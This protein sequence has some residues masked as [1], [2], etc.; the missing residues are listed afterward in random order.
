MVPA[1]PDAPHVNP[2]PEARNRTETPKP[3]GEATSSLTLTIWGPDFMAPLDEV[4]GGPALAGQ[5]RAFEEAS[6]NCRVHYVRKKPYGQG[7]LVH[8]I[9]STQ[10]VAPE[11]LPDLALVDM[12]EI[13]LLAEASL[14]QPLDS[15]VDPQIV[16]DL[17][18]FARDAGQ[19]GDH[20]LALQYETD[21]RFLAYNSAIIAQPPGTWAQVLALQPNYLLPIGATDGAVL[22]SFLPQYLALG[23]KLVDRDGRPYL[24]R[25]LVEAILEVYRSGRATGVLPAA[26]FDLDDASDCWP[27]YLTSRAAMT[28]VNSW[29]YGRERANRLAATQ[30]APMPTLSGAQISMSNGWGWVVL[31]DDPKRQAAAADFLRAIFEPEA[32]AAWSRVT[33]HLPTRRAALSLAVDDAGYRNFL[34]ELA[35]V[36]VPQPREPVLSLATEALREAIESVTRGRQTP[37]AAAAEAADRV[38]TAL[39]QPETSSQ[40]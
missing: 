2:A 9:Q 14:L 37:R 28:N 36:T 16:S 40:N 13:G 31:T 20:L 6:T 21:F 17:M 24:D 23:G 11:M 1:T 5:I 7:G 22:D 19:V 29:D 30:V 15:L 27:V 38:Q 39:E 33:F 32:M 25:T 4:T 10:A 34:L 35:A 26:G 8:F 12:S 18:P 3:T